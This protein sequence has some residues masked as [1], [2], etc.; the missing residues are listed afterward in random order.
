MK[1]SFVLL[2]RSILP[3]L[4]TAAI[5]AIPSA[6]AEE[7]ASGKANE[8]RARVVAAKEVDIAAR[9]DGRLARIHFS[10]GQI[11]KKGQPLFEFDTKFR[12]L[13]L[14]A[15][16]AKLRV[17]SAQLQLAD[18]KLQ[19]SEKLNKKDV[20]SD[21]KLLEA[22]AQ[23]EVAAA[24]VEEAASAVGGA[25][26]QLD[27]TAL[28]APIDGMIGPSA[29]REGAYVTLEALQTNRLATVVQLNPIHVVGQVPFE[30]FAKSRSLFMSRQEARD[31]LDY[32][33][34]LPGGYQYSHRGRLTAGSGAFD[35]STQTMAVIVEFDNP[36]HLLRPGLEV[37][38]RSSSRQ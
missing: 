34:I 32:A 7:A 17:A 33:L 30:V 19:A 36:D 31:G 2:M 24:T 4:A 21:L 26:L 35:P 28:F 3:A 27:Q 14:D 15:A 29:V 1:P 10:M 22:R 13:S 37:T 11:V 20:T 12:Q 9:I 5:V 6:T 25:Q 18:A 23:R 16:K 38:L 8:F